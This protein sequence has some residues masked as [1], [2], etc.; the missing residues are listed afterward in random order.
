MDKTQ[1]AKRIE[2]LRETINRHS[3]LY[4]VKDSPEITDAEFDVLM[5]ELESLEKEHP[6][7]VTPDSPTKRVGGEPLSDFEEFVHPFKM[8]SLA[9]ALNED[10]FTDFMIRMKKDAGANFVAESL[11]DGGAKPLVFS[12][13]HKFDGLA[14]ELIYEN[15]VLATAATRGNGEKGEL[16]TTNARTIRSIPLRLTGDYPAWLAVYG[17]VL[18]FK[19]D[20]HRL[21]EEREASGEQLFANPRNAAAGS[22]RQLD[23]KV[24][25]S[26]N[27][28]FL[29]Y[30]VRTRDN[31]RKVNHITS[32]YDRMSWL[33]S[34]GIPVGAKRLKTA[35][36]SDIE[37]F[38]ELWETERAELEYEIDGVVVKVDDIGMQAE[39]GFDAK[40]PKW[41]IAWKF[42][43]A[44]AETVLRSVEFSVGRMR[45]ITP[46]AL[47]DPVILAGARISRAT[48]H[49][50]DEVARLGVMI[51]DTIRVERSGEV[52]PKVVGVVTDKR[53][54][55]AKPIL[56]PTEC[57][58]CG[59]PVE[60]VEGEVA[61]RC[62]NPDCS[63]LAAEE[64]KHFVSRNAFDIEGIGEEI[65][66]RFFDL[67]LVR[68]FADIFH[69]K[70]RRAELLQ[71]DRFGEKSVE[72]LFASIESSRRIDYWRFI[73]SLSVKLV[74]EQTARVL[75][76]IFQPL[77]RLMSAAVEELTEAEG[78]GEVVAASIVEY[79]ADP[80]KRKRVEDL[81]AAGVEIVYPETAAKVE[82]AISGM[83]IVFTGKAEGFTREEF[84]ELV[85]KN[86]GSPS[87][88]VSSKTDLVVAGENAGSKLDKAKSLGVKVATPEEF[89][90]MLAMPGLPPDRK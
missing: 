14:I 32:H 54:A 68:T 85:R 5:K 17:E 70:D 71:L 26:R 50:F 72:N 39:L 10:E 61:Y 22:L 86:G 43:P 1:A 21:N 20:F 19:K 78:V 76:S 55:G 2:E 46:T 74:G 89:L 30:G 60:K 3:Y 37:A 63:A 36:V 88:S 57:P 73:N 62:A 82:S 80:V 69:L 13:E 12:C 64:I 38:H 45:T 4:Y 34:V 87:D 59:G 40:T 83:R 33:Q 7:L 47:F 84:E 27:L 52:I 25:A 79:F 67:G 35:E 24:T 49:N 9:N 18:M 75:A 23:P 16:I 56:P 11:F 44:V 58:V 77:D 65:V 53:P 8:M 90:A 29:A 51:G 81:I 31:D 6:E 28:R 42:K 15:G 48:L 66:Y 41:A